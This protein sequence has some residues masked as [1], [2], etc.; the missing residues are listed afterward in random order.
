[1]KENRM[2]LCLKISLL[3]RWLVNCILRESLHKTLK[4]IPQI[5]TQNHSLLVNKC[6]EK[7]HT[8]NEDTLEQRQSLNQM[9]FQN[10]TFKMYRRIMNS[11]KKLTTK[12]NSK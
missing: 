12:Q 8:F 11:V 9:E 7:M 5:K 1:M 3:N 2:I 4:C 6:K 10:L